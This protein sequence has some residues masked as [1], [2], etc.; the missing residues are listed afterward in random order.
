MKYENFVKNLTLNYFTDLKA[1]W[2]T[3]G[4]MTE[5]EWKLVGDASTTLVG[6][7]DNIQLNKQNIKN[8]LYDMAISLWR[9]MQDLPAYK[10]G[11]VS[12]VKKTTS[13]NWTTPTWR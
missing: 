6:Y 9:I 4:S 11:Q 2:A 5:W 12:T 13:S 1:E 10:G 3:F 8:E 7:Q